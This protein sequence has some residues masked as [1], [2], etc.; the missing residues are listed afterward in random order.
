MNFKP[1]IVFCLSAFQAYLWAWSYKLHAPRFPSDSMGRLDGAANWVKLEVNRGGVDVMLEFF[2]EVI[3]LI[4]LCKVVKRV[5]GYLDDALMIFYWNVYVPHMHC[6]LLASGNWITALWKD[7]WE[8]SPF[9]PHTLDR[10]KDRN[11]EAFLDL[12]TKSEP[13]PWLNHGDSKILRRSLRIQ[14]RVKRLSQGQE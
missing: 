14:A 7:A 6:Y 1:F 2:W 4:V 8:H 3:R 13:S 9:P 5:M 11:S 10:E 12:V